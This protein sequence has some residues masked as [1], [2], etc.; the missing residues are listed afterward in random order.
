LK[1]AP[2]APRTLWD[3]AHHD[4]SVFDDIREQDRPLHHPFDS[5][6]A[7]E[8]FVC[9][10]VADPNVV[11]IKMTLHRIGPDSPLIQQ[12]IDAAEAGKQVAVLVE[13]WK[14][15]VACSTPG[16]SASDRAYVLTGNQYDAAASGAGNR[17]NAQQE[18]LSWNTS[19]PALVEALE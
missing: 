3:A 13:L 11:A 12:L 5:F 8:T 9:Q 19:R 4:T 7:V 10:A 17:V 16:L 2:F 15:C 14:R 18:L 6:S 1:D